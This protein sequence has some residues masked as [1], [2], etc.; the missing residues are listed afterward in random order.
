MAVQLSPALERRL[1]KLSMK[2]PLFYKILAF[3]FMPYLFKSGLKINFHP[4]DFFAILPKKPINQNW[5]GTMGGGA[6]LGNV[7]LAA[8]AYLFM[9]T[10]GDYRM[11]CKSQDYRFVLPSMDSVMYKAS[12]NLAELRQKMASRD[13]F[14]IALD[15][16]VFRLAE[17]RKAGRRVGAGVINF[18]VWPIGA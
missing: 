10:G 2:S 14:D 7:E 9:M 12:V 5:Y 8:G 11:V 17:A 3:F 13:K 1:N 15:V 18:H 16:R 6:I 4:D